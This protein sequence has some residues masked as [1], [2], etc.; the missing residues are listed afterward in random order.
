MCHLLKP[1]KHCIFRH[2]DV[3]SRRLA[4]NS[5]FALKFIAVYVSFYHL[6]CALHE[7]VTESKRI[8]YL[9][10]PLK[11][12]AQEVGDHVSNTTRTL[13]FLS[14]VLMSLLFCVVGI[15]LPFQ[16]TF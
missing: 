11:T 8:V 4:L 9:K 10:F 6:R 13:I 15:F 14:F 12:C 2:T 1:Y 5:D 7:G 3:I 16:I